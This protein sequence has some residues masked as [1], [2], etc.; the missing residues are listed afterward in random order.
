MGESIPSIRT[1]RLL[2]RP[3][4]RTDA[5]ALLRVF[6][7]PQVMAAF[8]A[9]L[10]DRA[11]MERWVQRNLDHQVRYGYGLWTIVHAADQTIIG[12]CGLEQME[13]DGVLEAEL[14]YDLRSDYWNQGL[15]TEAAAAVRDWAFGSL[16]LPRLVSIIR[17]HNHASQRV[18]QKIGMTRSHM[19]PRGAVRYEVYMLDRPT[20]AE[21]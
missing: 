6:G 9:L 2:L 17:Q 19:L 10:F 15:A 8:D 7:D 1:A 12:D 21:S 13:L 11:Q 20:S 14:G 18:A 16:K 5:D 4:Q 3:M